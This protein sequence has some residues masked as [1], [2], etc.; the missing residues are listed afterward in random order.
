MKLIKLINILKNYI[1]N[2]SIY[3]ILS[4]LISNLRIETNIEN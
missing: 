1:E 3:F 2:D 4:S